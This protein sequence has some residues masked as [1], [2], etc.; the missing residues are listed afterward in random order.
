MFY[1]FYKYRVAPT[2]IQL[3][4]LWQIVRVSIACAQI[5]DYI[6]LSTTRVQK[7]G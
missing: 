2:A 4:L 3:N 6:F 5:L 7:I 1:F